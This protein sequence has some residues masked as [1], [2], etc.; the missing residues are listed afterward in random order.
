MELEGVYLGI[1]DHF[2]AKTSGNVFNICI[3][4]TYSLQHTSISKLTPR[5]FKKKKKNIRELFN[6]T[7]KTWFM[8]L[9]I[10]KY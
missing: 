1:L 2:K 3:P 8:M 6:S 10:H 4:Y 5:F 7:A 9:V